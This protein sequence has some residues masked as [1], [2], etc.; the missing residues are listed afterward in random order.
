MK[1]GTQFWSNPGQ[2]QTRIKAFFVG[3]FLHFSRL[4]VGDA[5][6]VNRES[7]AVGKIPKTDV[8][9]LATSEILEHGPKSIWFSHTQVNLY[10]RLHYNADFLGSMNQHIFDHR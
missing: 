4:Y 7:L 3:K 6:F 10:S 9:L 5:V 1:P 2:T 8:V